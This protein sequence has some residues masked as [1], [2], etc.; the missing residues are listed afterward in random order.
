MT[1]AY[2]ILAILMTGGTISTL[3][4]RLKRKIRKERL[5]LFNLRPKHTISLVAM[6][7]GMSISASTLLI[8]FTMDQDVRQAVFQPEIQ[9]KSEQ[10]TTVNQP[11]VE[12]KQ[13]SES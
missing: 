12:I 1:T 3:G 4:D 7:T 6:L 5:S 11:Q 9:S 2:I 10:L 13:V 8:L